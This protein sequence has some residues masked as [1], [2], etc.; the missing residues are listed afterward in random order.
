MLPRT[1]AGQKH[2]PRPVTQRTGNCRPWLDA[3]W[4]LVN[5]NVVI[6]FGKMSI[7][8]FLPRMPLEDAVGRAF[9]KDGLTYVPLPH[10]SGA[11]T[12]L[13][14]PAHRLLLADAI[15]RI[16]EARKKFVSHPQSQGSI[17]KVI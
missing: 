14:D 6:L 1:A 5:P 12:W 7:D 8:T 11:S 4:E 13:N 2:R 3:Q 15:Q 9:E 10:S 16:R 17:R